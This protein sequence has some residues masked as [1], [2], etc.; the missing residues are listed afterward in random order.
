[1]H[2]AVRRAVCQFHEAIED[3]IVVVGFTVQGWFVLARLCI[4]GL[5]LDSRRHWL[6]TALYCK[7]NRLDKF[8]GM[9]HG[10]EDGEAEM[11]VTR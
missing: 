8:D 6:S 10:R 2:V 1:M 5:P 4:A 7:D 11:D 3:I 9:A